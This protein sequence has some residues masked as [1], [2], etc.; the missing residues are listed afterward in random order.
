MNSLKDLL[1]GIDE[2]ESESSEG[3]WETSKGAAFGSLIL[4]NAIKIEYQLQQQNDKL[5]ADSAALVEALESLESSVSCGEETY[6][7]DSH[8]AARRLLK[9]VKGDV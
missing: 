5:T 2:Q 4:S 1:K 8:Q 7:S 6:G 3:W 9:Q